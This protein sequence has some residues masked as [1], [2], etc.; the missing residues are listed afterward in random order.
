ME[1]GPIFQPKFQWIVRTWEIQ[2]PRPN[3]NILV[4]FDIFHHLQLTA[5]KNLLPK[6]I[7]STSSRALS[8]YWHRRWCWFKCPKPWQ[9]HELQ[10]THTNA[11]CTRWEMSQKGH[12]TGHHPLANKPCLLRQ[13]KAPREPAYCQHCQQ[14]TGKWLHLWCQTRAY[15]IEGAQISFKIIHPTRKLTQNWSL[16]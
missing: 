4:F 8:H 10:N 5:S 9:T 3:T 14:A 15:T 12:N 6:I 1:E 7:A 16:L 11:M 2:T 13:T